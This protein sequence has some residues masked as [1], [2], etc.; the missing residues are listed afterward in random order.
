MHVGPDEITVKDTSSSFTPCPEGQH[1]VVAVDVI[2]LG[3]RV[4]SF[5]GRPTRITPKAAIVYQIEEINEDTGKRFEIA[6][7]KTVSMNPKAGLRLWLENWR[8]KKYTDE[9]AKKIGAPLHKL[10]GVNGLMTVEHK[11]SGSGR[12]Y[13]VATNITPK[14]RGLVAITP[15]EYDRQP[16]WAKRKEEYAAAV[17]AYRATQGHTLDESLDPP[18]EDVDDEIPF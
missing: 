12:L 14:P 13:G 17:S 5:A 8:G 18:P 15:H 11:T 6:V 3:E 10:I 16:F 9:E 2:N 7:E 4:E 1:L